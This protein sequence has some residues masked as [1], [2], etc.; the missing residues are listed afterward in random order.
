MIVSCGQRTQSRTWSSADDRLCVS[1]GVLHPGLVGIAQYRQRTSYVRDTEKLWGIS[2]SKFLVMILTSYLCG[3]RSSESEQ[4]LC[5]QIF[6]PNATAKPGIM[7]PETWMQGMEP[8]IN[9]AV[10]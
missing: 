3:V 6:D 10:W 4:D 1:L 9:N 8:T 5:Y 7:D 2:L